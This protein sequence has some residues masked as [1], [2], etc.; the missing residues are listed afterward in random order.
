MREMKLDNYMYDDNFVR[1]KLVRSNPGAILFNWLFFPGGPGA[2]SNYF[3]NL[4]DH[5]DVPGNFWLIDLP[6]NGSN[7]SENIP[8]DFNFD[9]WDECFIS[10]IHKFENPIIVGHSFGGMLPLLF[11]DLEN[12]LKG[13]IILNSA[14]SLWLVE[15]VKCASEKN[16][17]LLTE[18]M[19]NFERNPNQ[20]TFKRALLAC[21]PYY[22][23]AHNL[24]NGINLLNHIPFNYHAAVWWLKRATSMNFSAKWVPKNVSTLI[25][26]SSDDCIVPMT[27]FEQDKRF[28]RK[29]ISIEKIEEAGHFPWLEQMETVKAKFKAFVDKI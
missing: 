6:A 20:E 26:G 25:I 14:P 27:L 17:P 15:A 10:T 19:A 21:A 8:A 1:Y 3:V 5:L 28:F 22:F 12:L 4:I 7:I 29:N 13:F 2:D 24:E 18:P 16:L 11:P 9:S 23:P